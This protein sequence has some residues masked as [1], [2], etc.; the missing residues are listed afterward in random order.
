MTRFFELAGQKVAY[1]NEAKIL[2]TTIQ[3]P[4]FAA[5]KI[6]KWEK[7][8]PGLG[9]NKEIIDFVILHK[10]RLIIHV[11]SAGHDYWMNWD[12]VQQLQKM[13]NTEYRVGGST[14]LCVLPWREF[15]GFNRPE[16]EA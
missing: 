11:A 7:S 13:L 15:V 12:R 4:F 6:L 1:N 5:S 8:S 3:E 2:K 10:C 16:M 14:W 9:L